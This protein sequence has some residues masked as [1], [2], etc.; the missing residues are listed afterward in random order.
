MAQAMN[1]GLI[2]SGRISQANER[3]N[4]MPISEAAYNSEFAPDVRGEEAPREKLN[5][6]SGWLNLKA[7]WR[8]PG[9][10]NT[11]E[12]LPDLHARWLALVKAETAAVVAP[13]AFSIRLGETA[14]GP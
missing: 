1:A 3:L 9:A 6:D 4:T 10:E 11:N 8:V 7:T 12:T 13:Q 14:L 2:Q 5:G